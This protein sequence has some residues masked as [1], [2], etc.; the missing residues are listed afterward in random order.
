MDRPCR[1]RRWRRCR[2]SDRRPGLT[3]RRV[4]DPGEPELLFEPRHPR[5][6]ADRP[7]GSEPDGHLERELPGRCLGG[8]EQLGRRQNRG[9]R[10]TGR[11]DERARRRVAHVRVRRSGRSGRR[12]RKRRAERRVVC[13]PDAPL[14][15]QVDAVRTGLLVG[16][17]A[18]GGEPRSLARSS[19]RRARSTRPP[20]RL[21]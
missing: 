12:L 16:R 7:D 10:P 6:L 13:D 3:G 15:R 9:L 21:T 1:R 17:V 18:T 14:E 8:P 2:D 5:F 20:P 4:S 11:H 19:S